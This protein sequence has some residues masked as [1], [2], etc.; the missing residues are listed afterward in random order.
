MTAGEDPVADDTAVETVEIRIKGRI[1]AASFA[2]F[3]SHY[4]RRLDLDGGCRMADADT[5]TITVK[6]R[7][8]LVEMLATACSLGPARSLVNDIQVRRRPGETTPGKT[9]D[10]DSY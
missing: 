2:E 1:D 7:R 9:R 3:V 10:P 8:A 5:L 6:G 4:S